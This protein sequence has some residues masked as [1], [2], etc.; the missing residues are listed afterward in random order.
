MSKILITGATGHLGKGS[1]EFLLN[2]G[3][4]AS[5]IVA[6]A[7]DINKAT[8]LIRKG[9]EVRIGSFDDVA[10]LENATQGIEKVLLV[11]GLDQNRLQQHKN[12]V[13]ASKKSGVKHIAYTGVSLKDVNTSTNPTMA[14]HFQTEAYI[15]ENGFTYTFLRNSLYSDAIPMFAGENAVEAGI[16]LPAGNGKV[17]FVL[18]N[19]LA[20]ATASV[21]SQS[22]HENKTYNLT[23]DLHSFADIAGILSELSGK[24]VSY[25]D[26]D[27][28]I[29]P[30]VLKQAGV[31][32][33][34]IFVLSS[35]SADIKQGLFEVN[36]TDLELL[37]GRKP[38]SLKDTLRKIYN[39]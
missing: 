25:I 29:F 37:L 16:F 4:K 38:V 3:I 17:P 12:V 8:S 9:V 33:I 1:I 26:A 15:K 22:G 5:Q 19:D 23:G 13:D 18:R 24:T 35:F 20:E 2:K 36:S 27:A 11:S 10:S 6:L 28:K 7:R 31:P 21:L 39:L 14:D 34:G 32:E 30:E